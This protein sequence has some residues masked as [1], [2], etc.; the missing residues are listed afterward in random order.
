MT[1][2][3]VSSCRYSCCSAIT[4]H[5]SRRLV[6]ELGQDAKKRLQLLAAQWNTGVNNLATRLA[7]N[8]TTTSRA[9]VSENTA[10]ANETRGLL[11]DNDD[12]GEEMEMSFAATNK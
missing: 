4:T 3:W 9:G 1:H 5:P 10:A 11:D 7:G 12:N 6:T 8:S 2:C